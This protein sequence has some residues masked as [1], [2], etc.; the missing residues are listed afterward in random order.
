MIVS[1]KFAHILGDFLIF[2]KVYSFFLCARLTEVKDEL[3]ERMAEI[4]KTAQKVR[5]KL[6][7]I[8]NLESDPQT[9][10]STLF[11]TRKIDLKPHLGTFSRKI[12]KKQNIYIYS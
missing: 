9:T 2:K 4:K 3:E 6:K 8:P 1:E 7:G 12:I 11:A 10:V 5:A